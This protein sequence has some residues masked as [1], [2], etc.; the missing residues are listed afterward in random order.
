MSPPAA[1]GRVAVA[2]GYLVQAA[3]RA[4][5]VVQRHVAAAVGHGVGTVQSI[6][7]ARVL[8]QQGAGAAGGVGP[9]R[10]RQAQRVAV[11]FRVAGGE[12]AT[13]DQLMAVGPVVGRELALGIGDL[14]ELLLP[15]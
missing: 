7:A 14:H 2:V 3:G 1:F 15:S 11:D 12:V 13:A 6:I 4:V 5:V 8:H 9:F 10:L